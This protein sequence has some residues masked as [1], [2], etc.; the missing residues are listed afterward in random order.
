MSDLPVTIEN[1]RQT[2]QPTTRSVLLAEPWF[3]GSHRQWA[4]GW[5]ATSSHRVTILGHEANFWR[6]RLRGGAVTLAEEIRTHIDEHGAPDV[7][8]ISAMV[9]IAAL[10]GLCRAQLGGVPVIGYFHENQLTYRSD[11]GHTVPVEAA[12]TNWV[13]A[14]ACDEVW[15][16]S[17]F[18]RDSFLGALPE[19]LERQPDHR[20]T[21]MIAELASRAV[22][23]PV[24]VDLGAFRAA[25]GSRDPGM[26]SGDPPRI[27]WNQRWDHDKCPEV[28]FRV[29][30]HLAGEGIAFT[31]AL[32]GENRRSDPQEF[33][34]FVDSYP[35][36]VEEHGYLGPSEYVALLGR[37]DVVCSTALQEFFGISVVEAIAAG[38]IPLLPHRLAYPEVIPAEFHPEVL[39][40]AQ[41]PDV[42][43]GPATLTGRLRRVLTNLE[44]ARRAVAGL[45]ETMDRFDWSDVAPRYDVG[46]DEL[47]RRCSAADTLKP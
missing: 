9:D 18:H 46:I 4:E 10:V 25:R 33:R 1:T 27:V 29:L 39:Y 34:R 20:H 17:A 14:Q 44:A 36:R 28:F 47:F 2:T 15:F 32:A 24:G 45:A 30:R 16:N 6:W 21:H 43:D 26:E 13:S 23:M 38:A 40:V 37:S 3:G 12:M 7:L 5:A 19:F 41:A 8:V 35:D 31:V 22:V 11:P 42:G